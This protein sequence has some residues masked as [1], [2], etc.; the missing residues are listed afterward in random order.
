MVSV[1]NEPIT[2]SVV[3]LNV[4]MLSVLAPDWGLQY[5][6][7]IIWIASVAKMEDSTKK[8][9]YKR[10]FNKTFYSCNLSRCTKSDFVLDN[11]FIV[12]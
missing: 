1:I 2:L 3:M 5:I 6:L 12:V 10:L 8:Y 9:S 4:I 11:A 7:F